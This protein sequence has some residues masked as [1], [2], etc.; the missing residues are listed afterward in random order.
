MDII[1]TEFLNNTAQSWL[2]ALMMAGVE[3]AGLYGFKRFAASWLSTLV[4]RTESEW[5]DAFADLLTRTHSLFLFIIALFIGSL[6]LTMPETLRRSVF[7]VMTISLLVQGGLWLN[8]L[9]L[10]LLQRD[11]QRRRE[12]DPASV[13]TV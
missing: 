11:A 9:T 2:V 1:S 6:F 8:G 12:K 7:S 5:G 3:L 13:M 10:F 4:K